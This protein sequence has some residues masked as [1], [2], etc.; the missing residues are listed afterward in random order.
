M[1]FHH[2]RKKISAYSL[3]LIDAYKKCLTLWWRMRERMCESDKEWVTMLHIDLAWGWSRPIA[4]LLACHHAALQDHYASNPHIFNLKHFALGYCTHLSFSRATSVNVLHCYLI[5]CE[6]ECNVDIIFHA[7]SVF[8]C[9][10]YK[11]ICVYTFNKFSLQ[12]EYIIKYGIYFLFN[13]AK[14][15]NK[16]IWCTTFIWRKGLL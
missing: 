1:W 16:S 6:K 14:K 15:W 8:E 2:V 12:S 10:K 9:H 13:L 5:V 3:L 11:R 7:S 4:C